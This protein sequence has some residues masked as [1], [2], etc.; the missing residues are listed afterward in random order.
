[1]KKLLF[2]FEILLLNIFMC[3]AID[4]TNNSLNVTK[5]VIIT[6]LEGILYFQVPVCNEWINGCHVL[7]NNDDTGRLVSFVSATYISAF[8][9]FEEE[10]PFDMFYVSDSNSGRKV[11]FKKGDKI[12]LLLPDNS[13]FEETYAIEK[14]GCGFIYIKKLKL[15][16]EDDNV[17]EKRKALTQQCKRELAEKILEKYDIAEISYQKLMA[18]HQSGGNYVSSPLFAVGDFVFIP[19]LLLYVNDAARQAEGWI[20]LVS[21]APVSHGIDNC[22]IIKTK[23]PFS[24]QVMWNSKGYPVI[25]QK[26]YLKF[27]GTESY[28]KNMTEKEGFV[29]QLSNETEYNEHKRKINE[30]IIDIKNNPQ[31]HIYI[32]SGKNK[33]DKTFLTGN[34]AFTFKGG[35]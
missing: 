14:T 1:M 32:L 11:S 2:F 23:T 5:K 22:F 21:F 30:E 7:I 35:Q 9:D 34:N 29:F 17:A 18:F 26:T 31:K 20:Y 3:N 15:K 13:T 33:K 25:N 27:S 24:P 4:V 8:E 28:L 6:D 12:V 10:M 16:N 19:E